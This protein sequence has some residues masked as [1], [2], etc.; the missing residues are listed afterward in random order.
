MFPSILPLPELPLEGM[1]EMGLC[2][3]IMLLV[4]LLFQ[5]SVPA[6]STGEGSM[7]NC[8]CVVGV[9]VI[10]RWENALM[11]FVI[12]YFLHYS[13]T[14][15]KFQ[16]TKMEKGLTLGSLPVEMDNVCG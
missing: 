6:K 10:F 7:A 8:C 12:C 14:N 16:L 2:K 15:Y 13:L 11:L 9:F 5:R 1:R 4:L 3:A